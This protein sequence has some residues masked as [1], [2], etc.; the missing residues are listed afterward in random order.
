MCFLAQTLARSRTHRLLWFVY[1]GAAAA[2]ILN[3]SLIDGAFLVRSQGFT[4]ALRFLVLF[5][6]LACSVV[7]LNGFRHVLSIPVELRANWIFQLT[8]SQGR[9]E[10]MSAV[11]RFVMA[12]AVAPIYLILFPV[13]AYV[14]GWPI[15]IRMT[16]LQLLVTL[17]IFEVLFH[18]WQK[19]PFTCSYVPGKLPL[20]G[21]VGKYLAML[22]AVVPILTVVIAT[23]SQVWFLFPFYLAD[24]GG[25]YIWLR[26]NR[27]E[28]WGEA[29]LLYE[30]LPAVTDLGIKDLTYAGAEAQLRRTAAEL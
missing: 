17:S 30:D 2:V 13:A 28:G 10:W 8:E 21:V 24:I 12:Y 9:A 29:K 26:R 1:L 20:V 16:I 18:S 15:A 4:K 11:E 6:P 3:S 25:V 19:L 5:W 7:I 23:S 27:R 14:M 22:C